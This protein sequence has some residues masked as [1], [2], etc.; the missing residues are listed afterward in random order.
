[1]I[2]LACPYSHTDATVREQRFEAVCAAA[3]LLIRE[4]HQVFAP[5]VHGHPLTRFG[6][7]TGWDF[8]EPHVRQHLE[9]CHEVLVLTLDGWDQSVGVAAEITIAQSLGKPIWY[10]APVVTRAPT[11]A[12]VASQPF[13]MPIVPF[14][15][16]EPQ[17]AP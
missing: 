14:V 7:P 11:L 2:Y 8:W 12:H 5:V 16:L 13:G 6:L 17:E 4:G 10:R 15:T 9:R 1:M 3:A